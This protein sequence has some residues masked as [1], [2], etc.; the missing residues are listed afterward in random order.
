VSVVND[1][2]PLGAKNFNHDL[3]HY[4]LVM[5]TTNSHDSG[6]GSMATT[7]FA[8]LVRFR[9]SFLEWVSFRAHRNVR[10]TGSRAIL[11]RPALRWHYRVLCLGTLKQEF[12]NLYHRME[13][14]RSGHPCRTDRT[15]LSPSEL[16]ELARPFQG[17]LLHARISQHPKVADHPSD[18]NSDGSSCR[19]NVN[20]SS[21]EVTRAIG[22]QRSNVEVFIMISNPFC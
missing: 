21:S 9:T 3:A 14:L 12:C 2:T 16:T 20:P 4:P 17:K 11:E 8:F 7:A 18:G 5:H 10:S 1:S 22:R 19:G 15:P 13:I 6:A